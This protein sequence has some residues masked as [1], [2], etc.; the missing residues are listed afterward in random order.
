MAIRASGPRGSVP[1]QIR[2]Q[3]LRRRP[4]AGP[5]IAAMA[6]PVVPEGAAKGPRKAAAQRS[7]QWR[8]SDVRRAINAA[9]KAGLA[10]YRVEIAPDG[11]I[12]II[13]GDPADTAP[14]PAR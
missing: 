2:A 8:Q 13:V 3:A 14:V 11:T 5:Q 12:A 9:E 1:I 4:A 10:S 6:F 7:G